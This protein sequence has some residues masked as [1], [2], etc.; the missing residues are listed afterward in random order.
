M[1]NTDELSEIVAGH[2]EWLLVR[3]LG[4]T[5]PLERREIE[6]VRDGEKAHFGFLDDKGFHSWRL[7]GFARQGSEIAIDVAGAF[8]KKQEIM[9][10]VPRI[11]ASELN[12]EIELAPAAEV[13]RTD[14]DLRDADAGWKELLVGKISP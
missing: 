8:A 2:H 14:I 1:V 11:A 4:K 9:R 7:N 10:L 12:A 5:F 3:E 6:I 13:L